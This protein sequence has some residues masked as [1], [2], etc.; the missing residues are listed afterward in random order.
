[1]EDTLNSILEA[2]D[3]IDLSYVYWEPV[4]PAFEPIFDLQ[5]FL[6][7]VESLCH[8]KDMEDEVNEA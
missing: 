8:E 2:I 1:M 5:E 7:T 3:N 6:P 4:K